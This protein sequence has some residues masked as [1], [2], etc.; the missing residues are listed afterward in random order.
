[1][2]LELLREIVDVAV[3]AKVSRPKITL[4]APKAI[5]IC[6]LAPVANP[7]V[8]LPQIIHNV[9]SEALRHSMSGLP[10]PEKPPGDNTSIAAFQSAPPR[11]N[12][13]RL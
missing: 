12:F 10:S 13:T 9:P 11:S 8:P 1:M 5:P 3:T 4:A 7:S 6:S 2:L